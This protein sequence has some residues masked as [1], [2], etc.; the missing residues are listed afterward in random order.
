MKLGLIGLGIFFLA[1]PAVA[2]TFLDT[3]DNGK[4]VD[5]QTLIMFDLDDPGSWEIVDGE[6]QAINFGALTLLTIGEEIWKDY[7]IEFDVKPFEKHGPGSIAVAA[8]IEGT[9]GVVCRVGDSWDPGK[10]TVECFSG[11]LHG[12]AFVVYSEEPHRFLKLR[13]WTTF[14]LSVHGKQLIFSING[15]QVLDPITLEPLHGFP[16]FLTGNVGLGL[17]GYTARFDNFKITG[18]RIPDKNRL[19][20]TPQAKLAMTWGNLKQSFPKT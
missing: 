9:W 2:G 12:R 10:P 17:A 3:F 20:V 5:W 18:P 15:K 7:D 19:S 13:K 1:F 6:L 14:K 16:G 8:R 11:D 4:L